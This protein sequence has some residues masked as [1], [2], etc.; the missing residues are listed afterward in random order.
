VQ[1]LIVNSYDPS[2]VLRVRG[3]HAASPS[4]AGTFVRATRAH[5]SR[6]LSRR[7]ASWRL[8]PVHAALLLVCGLL[9]PRALPVGLGRFFI[10]PSHLVHPREVHHV[11]LPWG[12][13]Y[14]RQ[15]W[16]R[17]SRCTTLLL[18]EVVDRRRSVF[19]RSDELRARRARSPTR[20]LRNLQ[21]E[22]GRH[23]PHPERERTAGFQKSISKSVSSPPVS[24]EGTF[25]SV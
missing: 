16:I 7:S 6:S 23:V 25:A 12:M 20:S 18:K 10:G 11:G 3:R 22:E 21:L 8:S 14:L 4:A 24:W 1:D 17:S 13:A 5:G 9:L 19:H 15:A 2:H